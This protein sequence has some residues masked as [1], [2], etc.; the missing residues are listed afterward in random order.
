[1]KIRLSIPRALHKKAYMLARVH[2]TRFHYRLDFRNADIQYIHPLLDP[3]GKIGVFFEVKFSSLEHPDN[4]F[5]IISLSKSFPPIIM[6]AFEGRAR[7]EYL[8][9]K[10]GHLNF[11]T[12]FYSPS[13]MVAEDDNGK[14][15]SDLGQRPPV[16]C[17]KDKVPSKHFKGLNDY[18]VFKKCFI[19]QR[20]IYLKKAKKA[21]DDSWKLVEEIIASGG[22]SVNRSD[23]PT[24]LSSLPNHYY[25]EI[26]AIFSESIPAYKQIDPYVGA[27]GGTYGNDFHTGCA[28]TA[29]MS[30]IGY[31]DNTITPDL[32]RGTHASNST[33]FNGYQD[34]IMEKLSWALQTHADGDQGKVHWHDMDKGYDFIRKNLNH[35]IE[36]ENSDDGASRIR[37]LQTVMDNLSINRVPSIVA[38]PNHYVV[39]YGVVINLDDASEDGLSTSDHYYKVYWG[40]GSRNDDVYIP[41]ELASNGY[42]TLRRIN[43]MS[44]VNTGIRTTLRSSIPVF[45]DLG[46]RI[47]MGLRTN[48]NKIKFYRSDDGRNFSYSF[49]I[50]S[51]GKRAPS[52]ALEPSGKYLYIAW[53]QLDGSLSLAKLDIFSNR[54]G[55]LKILQAPPNNQPCSGSAIAIH[56]GKLYYLWAENIAYTP[57]EWLELYSNP[58]PFERNQTFEMFGQVG[59]WNKWDRTGYMSAFLG[60]GGSRTEPSLISNGEYIFVGSWRRVQ[61]I[62]PEETNTVTVL[63]DNGEPVYG[64]TGKLLECESGQYLCYFRNSLYGSTLGPISYTR[65]EK[66]RT[67]DPYAPPLIVPSK[68]NSEAILWPYNTGARV[69]LGSFKR[70][71][72]DSGHGDG[73]LGPCLFSSWIDTNGFVRIR[74]H[75][76]DEPGNRLDYSAW[77]L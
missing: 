24:D 71:D 50:V 55:S 12:V 10:V 68:L 7:T 37:T 9:E 59:G 23:Y 76:I 63:D 30:L 58:W 26:L 60:E 64:N 19:L 4:G 61:D 51:N 22:T 1:M 74:Y 27:N 15:L 73:N 65:I 66:V 11:N 46:D 49:E 75:S 20:D 25:K 31:Y 72:L 8:T 38:L 69:V 28:A 44:E 56:K 21:F 16:L 17:T 42:W 54:E 41:Y 32:L 43:S 67:S 57:L 47:L 70:F 13:Y 40:S 45:I 18:E 35:T 52:F 77:I 62:R 53:N 3:S 33:D 14:M 36:G 48:N 5:L 6:F 34:H 29:W 39:A 2:M